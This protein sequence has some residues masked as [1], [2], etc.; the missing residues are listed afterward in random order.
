MGR[1]LASCESQSRDGDDCDHHDDGADYEQHNILVA[2][3]SS[4][5]NNNRCI[6]RRL[7]AQSAQVPRTLIQ[8]AVNFAVCLTNQI[9]ERARE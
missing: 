7:S 8:Q 3:R 1:P 2:S 6:L 9:A 5:G 4:L